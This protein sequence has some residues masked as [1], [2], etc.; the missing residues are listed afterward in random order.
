MNPAKSFIPDKYNNHIELNKLNR[1]KYF[2]KSIL[3]IRAWEFSEEG[4]I[5]C[6]NITSAEEKLIVWHKELPT[7]K[8]GDTVYIEFKNGHPDMVS[9]W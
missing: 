3:E 9:K 2:T 7:Y 5:S 8:E 6:A 1:I 4:V